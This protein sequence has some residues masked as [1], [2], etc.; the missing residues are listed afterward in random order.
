[1]FSNYFPN[2]AKGRI[3]KTEMLENLR[4]FPRDFLDIYYQSYSNGVIAGAGLIV[5]ANTLTV[6]RGIIKY[7]GKIYLLR[8]PYE[9]PYYNTNLEMVV[10]VHFF[11]PTVG[12]DFT[13]A[14]T[15]ISIDEVNTLGPQELELGRFKLRE[16]AQLRSDY[17]DFF[18]F[19]TEFNTINIIQVEYAGVGKSTLAPLL[20]KYFAS[21]VIKSNTTNVYDIAFAMECL[22]QER[23]ERDLII[24]YL[25]QRQGIPVKDYSNKEIYRYLTLIVKELGSGVRRNTDQR[26]KRPGR[27]VVD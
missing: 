23:V 27:I 8:E 25:A 3:L 5:G 21:V 26:Q 17:K 20:L 11:E 19:N 1:M 13:T 9:T 14:K 6:T 24:Y 15:K 10:K 12:S 4:D 22:N 7:N 16:G 2:F 18:D